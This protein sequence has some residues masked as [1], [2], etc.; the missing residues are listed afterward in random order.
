M[1][2]LKNTRKNRGDLFLLILWTITVTFFAL[3]IFETKKPYVLTFF[4]WVLPVFYLFYRYRLNVR[5]IL[6]GSILIGFVIPLPLDFLSRDCCQ[7]DKLVKSWWNK[8][9]YQGR[10]TCFINFVSIVAGFWERFEDF[11][12]IRR[13]L[14]LS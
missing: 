6:L 5:K 13:D 7:R 4:Y 14:S 2:A 11:E 3:V 8:L 12:H 1:R 9:S 10:L